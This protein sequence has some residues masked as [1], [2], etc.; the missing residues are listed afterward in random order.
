MMKSKESACNTGDPGSIPVLGR[1]PGEENGNPLQIIAWRIPW[2][3]EPDRSTKL[4]IVRHDWA[5]NTHTH[6]MKKT[7][8]FPWHER[9]N[10]VCF[11]KHFSIASLFGSG[12]PGSL[13]SCLQWWWWTSL[14]P[15]PD[16]CLS[17]GPRNISAS[18]WQPMVWQCCLSTWPQITSLSLQLWWFFH[19]SGSWWFPSQEIIT[20]YRY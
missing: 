1:S 4:Q 17:R 13:S 6:V 3:E 11:L 8:F 2:T 12:I 5:T 10:H 19:L 7:H 20:P 14:F 15:W 18:T 9:A 16:L